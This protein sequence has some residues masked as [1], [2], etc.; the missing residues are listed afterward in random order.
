[1]LLRDLAVSANSVETETGLM[2]AA[3]FAFYCL[4]L[5]RVILYSLTPAHAV[6]AE[7]LDTDISGSEPGPSLGWYDITL[8]PTPH[9]HL[10][11]VTTALASSACTLLVM[12]QLSPVQNFFEEVCDSKANR[13]E[14]NNLYSLGNG[15]P[16][17][18]TVSVLKNHLAK[19]HGEINVVDFH[20]C[21]HLY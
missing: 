21:L 2:P 10:R 16:I 20:F 13:T 12:V 11:G 6:P 4:C 3:F 9:T 14:C 1:M 5:L 15:Q 18:Q 7:L 17:F 8:S 19:C